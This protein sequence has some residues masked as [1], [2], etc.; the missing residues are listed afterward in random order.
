MCIKIPSA[1]TSLY[2]ML[3]LVVRLSLVFAIRF[4]PSRNTNGDITYAD[5][6]L[7]ALTCR[8]AVA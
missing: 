1:L 7:Q 8:I 4:V 2:A 5:V 6:F 3:L